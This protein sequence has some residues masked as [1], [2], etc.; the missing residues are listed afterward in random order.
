MFSFWCWYYI[1]FLGHLGCPFFFFFTS[2]RCM[3]SVYFKPSSNLWKKYMVNTYVT[4]V[5]KIGWKCSTND[6]MELVSF[7]TFKEG[8]PCFRIQNTKSMCKIILVPVWFSL[9]YQELRKAMDS[10][11]SIIYG[12]MFL[13][14]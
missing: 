7:I 9:L 14:K 5:L 1:L 8:H 3:C 10:H 6:V 13:W 4:K 11:C 2:L 12:L